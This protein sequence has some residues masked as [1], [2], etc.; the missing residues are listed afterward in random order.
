MEIKIVKFEEHGD[1]R[2]T[3]IA[4]EQMINVPFEIKR[5]YYMYN[6][7]P[8]VRR[9]FHEHKQL[10]Q[11]LVVYRHHHGRMHLSAS[12]DGN[13]KCDLRSGGNSPGGCDLHRRRIG[14]GS[15]NADREQ[16]CQRNHNQ[17]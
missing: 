8:G 14:C 12:A 17:N 10:K 2:G 3:L 7:V 13:G 9:G 16:H 1:S 6:A 11:I 4:L 15:R 5:V